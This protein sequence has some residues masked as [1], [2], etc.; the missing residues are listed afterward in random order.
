MIWK[1]LALSELLM[2]LGMF[3]WFL[4]SRRQ[5]KQTSQDLALFYASLGHEL[6]T[7]LNGIIGFSELLQAEGFTA[8]ERRQFAKDI[9]FSANTLLSMIHHILDYAKFNSGQMQIHPRPTDLAGLFQEIPRLLD[10]LLTEKKLQLKIE[11]AEDLPHLEIDPE[12]I[13]QILLNLIG[14]AIK[15]SDNGTIT[16]RGIFQTDQKTCGRLTIQVQDQG[17]GISEAYRKKIFDPFI[18]QKSHSAAGL[19][20]GLGLFITRSLIQLMNGMIELESELGKGSRFTVVLPEVPYE[21]R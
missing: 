11:L 6:K 10:P 4:R 3:Y 5:S 7:P 15:F 19:G 13:R 8:E 14:N 18:Q 2:M 20:S 17:Q 16:L 12:R 1:L 21:K 9:A